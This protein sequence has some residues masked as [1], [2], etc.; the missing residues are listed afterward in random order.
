[1]NVL[2][3]WITKWT[4]ETGH[5]LNRNKCYV[6]G[7]RPHSFVANATLANLVKNYAKVRVIDVIN[8]DPAYRSTLNMKTAKIHLNP[9]RSIPDSDFCK[10]RPLLG[11]T[12][13]A[14]KDKNGEEQPVFWP[15]QNS[16]IFILS[17]S[18]LNLFE[19]IDDKV[20]SNCNVFILTEMA[21]QPDDRYYD[22]EM[23]IK[24]QN[25]FI[26]VKKYLIDK[27][28]AEKITSYSASWHVPHVKLFCFHVV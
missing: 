24:T 16:D 15:I 3:L 5:I 7:G 18:W 9:Y 8:P 27:K 21:E 1:M 2:D 4:Q 22:L 17:P 28:D 26:N 12:W 19:N 25:R 10:I 20:Q 13:D 23:R 11:Y 6:I 14:V